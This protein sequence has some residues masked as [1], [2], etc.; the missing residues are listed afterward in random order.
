MITFDKMKYFSLYIK[1][2]IVSSRLIEKEYFRTMIVYFSD[3][4]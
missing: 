4:P 2:F 1:I 3:V